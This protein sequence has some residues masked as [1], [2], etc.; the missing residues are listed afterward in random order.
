[1]QLSGAVG[2]L[3][4]FGLALG[5]SIK[6]S[7]ARETELN[8]Q[9]TTS[10]EVEREVK[11]ELELLHQ[12]TVDVAVTLQRSLLPL[13][14]P[15][16]E[17]FQFGVCYQSAT[18]QALIGGDFYDFF[19]LDGDRLGVII[20]DVSGKGVGVTAVSALVK[21]V[22]RAFA[23]EE[24]SPAEALRRANGVVSQSLG[25]GKFITVFF[26]VIDRA[27][28]LAYVNCGHNPP[29]LLRPGKSTSEIVTLSHGTL[30]L[31]LGDDFQ[32]GREHAARIE[33]GGALVLYT[34][35]LVEARQ[36]EEF[37]GEGR[38]SELALANLDQ[39]AQGIT[40]TLCQAVNSFSS[41]AFADDAAIVTIKRSP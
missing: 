24:Q 25:A 18:K 10:I 40:D 14:T 13:R 3:L 41:E 8:D 6:R 29:L 22:I 4:L 23:F 37:Y 1:L 38:I 7:Y 26:G 34:D 11:D 31:G 21:N 2:V 30:P 17:P 28:H 36:G 35:G 5:R 12:R 27:G 15:S 9:L 16:F 39:P 32:E 33:P 20:G 19:K